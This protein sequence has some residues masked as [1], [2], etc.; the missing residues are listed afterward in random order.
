VSLVEAWDVELFRWINRGW[1]HPVMDG[2]MRFLSG[3]AFFAPSLALLALALLWR[4]GRRG[5]VF[6]VILAV[7]AG[8]ANALVADPLK[9]GIRR[10]R[11]YAVLPDV[12]L[13]VGRGNPLGSMPSAHAMNC[14]L[15]ATVA[16]WY[17][18]R[19]LRFTAPV[20]LGVAVSRVYNGAHFP[21]DVLTGA[22]LGVASGLLVIEV[23]DQA[24][25]WAG[26]RWMPGR[27][28]LMPSLKHPDRVLAVAD[29]AGSGEGGRAA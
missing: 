9:R 16:G 8:L 11:P 20:A 3:N 13:R 1:S 28:A 15:M 2:A 26:N 25:R 23:A 7:A 24:W 19:S 10:S 14:G 5:R 27:L 22:A 4:G 6:V 17:Y 18:R 21:S 12:V 29:S